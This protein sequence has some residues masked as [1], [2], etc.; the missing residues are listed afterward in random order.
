MSNIKIFILSW[1]FTYYLFIYVL[2]VVNIL[3]IIFKIHIDNYVAKFY[4]VL[5]NK[6]KFEVGK[7]DTLT[8][9]QRIVL[10]FMVSADRKKAAYRFEDGSKNTSRCGLLFPQHKQKKRATKEKAAPNLP[11]TKAAPI[12]KKG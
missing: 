8:E 5:V 2:L 4:H 6:R 3:Q 1:F 9:W 12:K 7:N 10:S 11:R